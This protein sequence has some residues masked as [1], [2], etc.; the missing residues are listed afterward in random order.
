MA[1]LA[2]YPLRVLCV[3]HCLFWS[4]LV[5]PDCSLSG[6]P[7][8]ALALFSQMDRAVLVVARLAASLVGGHLYFSVMSAVL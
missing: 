4:G 5:W 2:C 3:S 6:G 1:L 8:N 7:P